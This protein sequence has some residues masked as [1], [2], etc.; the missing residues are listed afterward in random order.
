MA[1]TTS[2]TSRLH[3]FK[4][5]VVKALI[6]TIY[7]AS[8]FCALVFLS[9]SILEIDGIPYVGFGVAILKA[10]VS[11]KFMMMGLEL[12][13][14]PINKGSSLIFGVLRRSIV[15]VIVVVALSYLFSGIEGYF[16]HKGFVESLDEFAKGSIKHLMALAI[17]YWLIIVPY[18]A[19]SAFKEM[20]GEDKMREYLLG[21][22]K[23]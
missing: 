19:F 6:L 5:M 15:Y 1:K 8:W 21:F 4:E 11:A 16:H 9:N 2:N 14:L 7:L 3:K 18:L 20:I 22:R 17:T 13:P 10:A 23:G 12:F